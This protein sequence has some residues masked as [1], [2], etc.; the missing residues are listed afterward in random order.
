[1]MQPSAPNQCL[2]G[3][4]A[5]TTVK[6]DPGQQACLLFARILPHRYNRYIMHRHVYSTNNMEA[7]VR[8]LTGETNHRARSMPAVSTYPPAPLLKYLIYMN[9]S[10]CSIEAEVWALTGEA[11]RRATN[12]PFVS[13]YPAAPLHTC[14]LHRYIN[15]SFAVA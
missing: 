12:M 8:S 1:M 15:I 3:L 2:T 7:K 14:S 9:I 4:W 13:T 11:N 6:N 5:M 10:S